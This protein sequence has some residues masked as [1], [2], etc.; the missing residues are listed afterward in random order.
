[1]KTSIDIRNNEDL[2]L[3]PLAHFGCEADAINLLYRG[4]MMD[5]AHTY[6]NVELAH[7][8]NKV[9]QQTSV[10]NSAIRSLIRSRIQR[11]MSSASL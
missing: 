9:C 11:F 1:M 3:K 6:Q 5:D 8:V 10:N 2:L 4:P 7:K